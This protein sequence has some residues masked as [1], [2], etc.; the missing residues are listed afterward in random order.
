MPY[1][2]TEDS[3]VLP[4]ARMATFEYFSPSITTVQDEYSSSVQV[5]IKLSQSC[6][7]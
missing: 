1:A 3:D 7:A 2:A 5:S 4:L 6:A